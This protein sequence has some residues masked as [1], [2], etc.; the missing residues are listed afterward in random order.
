MKLKTIF[1]LAIGGGIYTSSIYTRQY[2]NLQGTNISMAQYQG[3]KMLLVNIASQ[4]EYAAV[5]LP[6][7]QQLYNQYEDSLIVVAFPSNDFG[8]EP[9]T[10]AELKL[11]MQNTYHIGF[12]V[13]V[14]TTVKDSLASVH[15]VYKWLQDQTEN[16]SINVKVKKDFQKYVVDK[17]GT[18]IGIFSSKTNPMDSAIIKTITQ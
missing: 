16:G 17:N 15:P 9:R 4:S 7:L 8:N 5:Q 1:L 3:K 18:I 6:Q 11:L 14:K 10:D 12:P 13:S 2:T